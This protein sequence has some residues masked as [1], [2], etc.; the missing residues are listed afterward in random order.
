MTNP[1]IFAAK[2][3]SVGLLTGSSL[4]GIQ[5]IEDL[6]WHEAIEAGKLNPWVTQSFVA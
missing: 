2:E 4:L 1:E 6:I 3:G 5:L